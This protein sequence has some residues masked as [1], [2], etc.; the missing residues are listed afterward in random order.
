MSLYPYNIVLF[1]HHDLQ[2]TFLEKYSTIVY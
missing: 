2:Y 1:N